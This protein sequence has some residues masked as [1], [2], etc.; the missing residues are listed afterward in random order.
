PEIDRCAELLQPHLG[1]DLRE[2]LYPPAG[3][4]GDA[5]ERLRQTAV[6]QPALFAVEYAL[7]KLWQHWGVAPRAMFGHSIGEYVAACLAGVFTL[8]DV[9]M[10]VATRGRLVQEQ[11]GGAM[12]AVRLAEAELAPLL[13]PGLDLAAV[14]GPAQCVASGPAEAVEALERQ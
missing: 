2:V 11:P 5:E 6:T 9:L 13:G 3:S 10:L 8:A 14:N 1:F 12:L 7:A 4:E